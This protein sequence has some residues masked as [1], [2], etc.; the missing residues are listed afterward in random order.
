MVK[1]GKI[2]KI[3]QNMENMIKYGKCGKIWQNMENMVKYVI[4]WN[5]WKI[6]ENMVELG[7]E[8]K[9]NSENQKIQEIGI[10]QSQKKHM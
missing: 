6:I 3:W 4:I 1:Y 9:W 2:W 10:L 5:I 7:A 8:Y